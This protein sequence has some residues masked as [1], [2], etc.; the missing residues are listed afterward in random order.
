M[1]RVTL[2]I[3]E[4]LCM[5]NCSAWAETPVFSQSLGPKAEHYNGF[6]AS[7]ISSMKVSV[8]THWVP[9]AGAIF[10]YP[11]KA[12]ISFINAPVCSVNEHPGEKPH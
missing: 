12:W 5:L 8:L 7:P 4:I 1:F 6:Q 9:G 11:S 2:I 10:F 3:L